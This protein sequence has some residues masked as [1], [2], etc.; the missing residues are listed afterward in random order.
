VCLF[1][2]CGPVAAVRLTHPDL[3]TFR[4]GGVTQVSRHAAVI[5]RGL[6]MK[7]TPQKPRPFS[8]SFAC[9]HAKKE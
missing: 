2:C 3:H 9:V 7:K 1:Y 6:R 8:R 4:I 5:R